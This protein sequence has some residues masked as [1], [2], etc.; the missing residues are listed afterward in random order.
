MNALVIGGAGYIGS[1]CV[2]Q[3]TAAGHRAVVLDN[4]TLGH[5]ASLSSKVPFYQGDLGDSVLLDRIFT[6]EKIEIVMHFAALASVGESV[7]EPLKYYGNNLAKPVRLLEAMINRGIRKFIFS[8]T[9]ATYGIP[10]TLPITENTPQKPINPYGQTKLD[11]EKLLEAV[12]RAHG[13]SFAAFRYFNAA[14][15]APD[16]S[17]G[18]DHE[19]EFSLVP[20]VIQTAMGNRKKLTIFGSDYPTPDGT[21]LRDYIHVDD[22][23]VAHIAAFGKLHREG[24]SLYYNLGTGRPHSVREVIASAERISGQSVATVVGPR[25]P[26]DPPSLYADPSKAERELH[27]KARYQE[28]DSIVETA[29]NWHRRHPAGFN[30]R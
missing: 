3:L 20:L 11:M 18:E 16:G 9:C 28:L 26:G 30:D 12:S 8:S 14:G 29:W 2:R 25:R 1:H 17:I 24:Q 4:L 19:P 22:L 7:A 6:C 27:W 5:R 23:C 15:A 21:C 13:L 10:K